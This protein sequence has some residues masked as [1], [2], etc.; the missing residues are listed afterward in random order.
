MANNDIIIGS[1]ISY[2]IDGAIDCKEDELYY[3]GPVTNEPEPGHFI[4]YSI[5]PQ[6]KTSSQNPARNKKLLDL[7]GFLM[8]FPKH[9]LNRNKIDN[10]Y[11]DER[12]PFAYNEC[13]WFNRFLTIGVIPKVVFKTFKKWYL[14]LSFIIIN[15]HYG[16]YRQHHRYNQCSPHTPLYSRVIIKQYDENNFHM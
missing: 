9:V 12:Y 1:D 4:Q 2:I 8:V 6:N 7:Y 3:Y 10:L 13:D 5:A 14:K 11:F 15:F 16:I